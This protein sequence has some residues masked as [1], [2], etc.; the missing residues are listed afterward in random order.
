LTTHINETQPGL[1]NLDYAVYLSELS[2]LK[3]V[4][5]MLEYMEEPEQYKAAVKY[6]EGVAQKNDLNFKEI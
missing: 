1:G 6:L 5:L 3:D 4:P 2:K